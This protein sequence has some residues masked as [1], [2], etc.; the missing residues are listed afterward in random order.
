MFFSPLWAQDLFRALRVLF[1]PAKILSSSWE[2]FQAEHASRQAG[3]A[4]RF[5]QGC[6][7][8]MTRGNHEND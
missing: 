7:K 1:L 6:G 3:S 5:L 4:G 2:A 8:E